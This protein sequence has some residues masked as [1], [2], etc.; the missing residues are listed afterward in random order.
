MQVSGDISLNH[1]LK[2]LKLYSLEQIA[3]D[4]YNTLSSQLFKYSRFVSGPT[5][6]NMMC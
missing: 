5:Y 4:F 1:K 6:Q 3:F 2:T